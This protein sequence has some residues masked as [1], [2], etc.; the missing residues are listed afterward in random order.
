MNIESNRR[1]LRLSY[2]TVGY[3]VLEGVASLLAGGAAGS[4]A[5][6]GFGLDSV[7]ESLSGGIMVW[8][9]RTD[10]P[11]ADAERAEHRAVRLVGYTF[12]VLGAFVLLDSA[13]KLW[14]GERPEGST[15]GIAITLVSLVVMP[16]LYVAKRRTA[17]TL[18]SRSLAADSKQTLACM[19]MSAGVL[20]GLVLN[21][22]LGLWQADPAVAIIIALLLF[23]EGREA[24]RE[25]TLCCC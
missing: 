8:R 3:N 15:L 16:L 2:F 19:G 24:L 18:G 1:A 12:F 14:A 9:F 20:L 22:W 5:L 13:R 21:R 6:V 4:A 23:R 25:G 10:R 17:R 7:V 11:H